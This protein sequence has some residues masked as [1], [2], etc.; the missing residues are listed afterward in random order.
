MDG[1]L[2]TVETWRGVQAWVEANHPSPAARRFVLTQMP[3]IVLARSGVYDG[4]AFRARWLGNQAR[5]LRGLPE[6]GLRDMAEWV[7]EHHLWPARRRVA[8]AA[9]AA[10]VADAQPNDSKSVVVL[11][12]G[13]YLQISE[14]FAARIGAD[15]AIGTPLEVEAGVATGRLADRVQTGPLKASAVRERVGD[16]PIL[17]A[18]GDSAADIPMLELARHPVAVSPDSGLRRTAM[19]RGWE[20]LEGD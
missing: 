20:L 12:S 13:A 8:I 6:A 11:A 9:L 19:S 3:F 16:V 18:F 2:S 7:V 5:L 1:T 15:I 17:T 4:E 10:A 14:A